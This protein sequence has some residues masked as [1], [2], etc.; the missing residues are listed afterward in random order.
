MFEH[1][2]LK[3]D[4]TSCN[5]LVGKKVKIYLTRE[6]L[7]KQ[8]YEGIICEVSLSSNEPHIPFDI[9]VKLGKNNKISLEIIGISKIEFL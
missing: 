5:R 9:T 1:E 2:I 3:L 6:D 4:S 8:E 7:D